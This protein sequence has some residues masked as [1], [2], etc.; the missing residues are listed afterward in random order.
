MDDEVECLPGLVEEVGHGHGEDVGRRCN[1]GH[2]TLGLGDQIQE[3]EDVFQG[4]LRNLIEV[5]LFELCQGHCGGES[6]D[7]VLTQR[8]YLLGLSEGGGLVD[9]VKVHP[10]FGTPGNVLS[11]VDQDLVVFDGVGK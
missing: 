9:V 1:G 6:P 7:F 4:F 5:D 11:V 8:R 3:L 10:G 2:H